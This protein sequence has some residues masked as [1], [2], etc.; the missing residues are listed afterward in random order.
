M[1]QDD[2]YSTHVEDRIN[3]EARMNMTKAL[4][5]LW[6]I[7][8]LTWGAAWAVTIMMRYFLRG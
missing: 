3:V 7:A 4:I 1:M 6:V 2:D 8:L 5:L